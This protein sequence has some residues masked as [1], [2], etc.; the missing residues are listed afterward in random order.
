MVHSIQRRQFLAWG[1]AGS[2]ATVSGCQTHAPAAAAVAVTNVAA[3]N[4]MLDLS[5]NENPYG[6]GPAARRAVRDATNRFCR[7]NDDRYF[8]LLDALAEHERVPRSQVLLGTGSGELLHMAALAFTRNGELLSAWPTYGQIMEYAKNFGAQLVKVPL[9]AN[10]RHDLAA[11]ARAVSAATQLVYICNPNNPTGTAVPG[12][13]LREFCLTIAERAPIVIDEAYLDL[14][15][16]GATESMVNLARAGRNVLVLRT[17]SKLH[18]LAGL[19]IGYGIGSPEMIARLKPLQMA[20]PNIAGIEAA[21]A[22]LGDRAFLETA[23][24]ALQADRRRVLYAARNLGLETADAQGNFVFIRTGIPIRTF[25][26]AM[27]ARGIE[28]GRPFEPY[29]DWC[30]ISIGTRSDTD[31]L[32]AALGAEIAASRNHPS[33]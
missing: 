29:T 8:A 13:A 14:A 11:M 27:R 28:V 24:A 5:S 7:Y 31:R 30:R 1:A 19:R 15:D 2:L 20:F 25:Q 10:H 16:P 9:D 17:F 3:P 32:L 26:Q 21:S 4:D 33:G 6:P 12:G 22:S 18:G 23:R